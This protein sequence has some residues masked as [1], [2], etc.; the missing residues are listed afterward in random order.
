MKEICKFENFD[1]KSIQKD[2]DQGM[3][4][5]EILKRYNLSWTKLDRAMESGIFIRGKIIKDPMTTEVKEKLS[6]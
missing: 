6:F 2:R 5:R 1:W 3:K 4:L